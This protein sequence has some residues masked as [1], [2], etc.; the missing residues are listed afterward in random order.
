MSWTRTSLRGVAE[1]ALGRQ[2]APQHADGPHMVPYL[3]AANVKDG[4][5]ALDDVMSMN[6]T[7]QEQKTFS[8]IPGDVLVTE[9]S[10]SLSSVGA[11][12]VWAGEIGGAV[13]FQNTLLRLRP[14][15]GV[16]D[17]RFLGWW[18]RSA[19]GSGLFASI[20]TGAN[21]YHVSAERVRSLPVELPSLEEQRRIA[22]FLDDKVAQI[23][24]IQKVRRESRALIVERRIVLVDALVR[25]ALDSDRVNADFFP[26]GEIS[27]RWRQGR[28]RNVECEVQTGPFGSQLHAE[29]YVDD[30]WPV[31][32]PANITPDGL[33][34]L[35]G[36]AV[37]EKIRMRLSRHILRED[38]V[39]FGRRGE[40]GRTGIVT[41]REA[42]WVCGTGSLRVRFK[43]D[44]FEAG[45]LSRYLSIPAIRHYFE[46]QSVGSTM[47]NLN[48]SILLSVP[49]LMP[50]LDEQR[51]IVERCRAVEDDC[52]KLVQGI[53]RQL[54]ILVER[55]QALITAA[56]TGNIDVTTA[57][58][59]RE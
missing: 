6:F 33:I 28:L 34:S 19:F 13:C 11:A 22:D 35:P 32:N 44:V 23:E 43:N 7:P 46:L 57:R 8:L 2:R 50:D 10:G 58:G 49:L 4:E 25:G 20:A 5:L 56:V 31:I 24:K 42:G 59:M 15:Q 38:D 29:D 26:L 30:G 37:G 47:A 17:G 48:T 55:K 9:G 12:A 40:L 53:E 39:V 18:A 52:R 41:S 16:T 3:R 51:E 1:V 45:Y 14:R 36:M 54:E 27:S 21:I